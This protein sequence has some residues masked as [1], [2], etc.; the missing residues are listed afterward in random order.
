MRQAE[1][2][3]KWGRGS[4]LRGKAIYM[5]GAWKWEKSWKYMWDLGQPSVHCCCF[6]STTHYLPTCLVCLVIDHVFI[7][8]RGK[9]DWHYFCPLP[10]LLSPVPAPCLSPLLLPSLQKWCHTTMPLLPPFWEE[11]QKTEKEEKGKGRHYLEWGW[12]MSSDQSPSLLSTSMGN[13]ERSILEG[14]SDEN[15]IEKD[16]AW[17]RHKKTWF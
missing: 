7:F 5:C 1:E 12:L 16:M 13:G 8:M 14:G 2:G 6:L 3:G 11:G 9:R 15:T 10:P 4:G 17:R